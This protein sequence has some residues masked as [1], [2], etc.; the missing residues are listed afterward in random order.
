MALQDEIQGLTPTAIVEMFELD[1][2]SLGGSINRFHSG[3]NELGASVVWKGNTY[4]PL[5]IKATGFE[6]TGQGVIP[7]PTLS[8]SNISGLIST[9][10]GTFDDLIGAKLTRERTLLKYLDA[11][12]FAAGNPDA[13]PAVFFP[14]EVY[15]V[16]Q[17]TSENKISIDFELTAAWDVEGVKLP[18]RQIL[19]NVCSW[20]Y[21]SAECS[22]A[23]GAVAEI[24]DTPTA[25]LDDDD[26][27][28]RVASCVL[29]FPD[30]AILPYGGFPGVGLIR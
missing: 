18:K 28:K 22:Y 9:L 12:N 10:I 2:T 7:R 8:V 29:R 30:P 3:L 5:P 19:Q 27:G 11:V 13:D 16:N 4:T 17:K 26:C 14:D 24:D 1:A 20:V 6:R 15:F 21:R 25:I 23:G